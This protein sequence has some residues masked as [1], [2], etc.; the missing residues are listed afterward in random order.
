MARRMSRKE[1]KR[2]EVAE[3]AGEARD[4]LEQ[5]LA[6]VLKSGAAILIV[7]FV[8]LAWQGWSRHSA[9]VARELL[10]GGIAA[11]EEAVSAG[12]GFEGV[13]ATFDEARDKGGRRPAGQLAGFYRG[14]TLFQ[15]GRLDE[16]VTA[17]EEV[18][19]LAEVSPTLAATTQSMLAR[20]Y[21]AA[22]RHED[23]VG[24][25]SAAVESAT[26]GFPQD[27][28]LL[29]LGRLHASVGRDELARE[30]WQRVLDEFPA[31]AAASEAR[32]L[33]GS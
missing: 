32:R 31:S 5:N 28:A 13:L 2:D 3:A 17:L 8:V 22:G 26:P 21:V 16:A 9:N 27:Q 20:V 23:A 4:W 24:I 7:A 12:S 33:L 10:A 18:A 11:Y 25:L 19:G 1:L 29:E 6:A 14:A 15:L 30:N